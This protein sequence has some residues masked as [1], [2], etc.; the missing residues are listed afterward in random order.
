MKNAMK[1]ILIKAVTVFAIGVPFKLLVIDNLIEPNYWLTVSYYS[2]LMLPPIF[3][4]PLFVS[5]IASDDELETLSSAIAIYTLFSIAL[6]ITYGI[7]V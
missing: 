4:F 7:L 5:E 6:F 1:L 2:F 3:A